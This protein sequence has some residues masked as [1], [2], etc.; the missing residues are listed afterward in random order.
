MPK[1][2]TT[3]LAPS[4]CHKAYKSIVVIAL[5]QAELTHRLLSL[6]YVRRYICTS[7]LP[8]LSHSPTDAMRRAVPSPTAGQ[9]ECHPVPN[10]TSSVLVLQSQFSCL[11]WGRR[12]CSRVQQFYI[13]DMSLVMPIELNPVVHTS[14]DPFLRQ[15]QGSQNVI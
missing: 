8:R 7:P 10:A 13:M 5:M 3:I 4:T 11:S 1:T 6:L 15:W 14:S 9:L 12:V 2:T